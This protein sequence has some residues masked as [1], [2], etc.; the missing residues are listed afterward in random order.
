MRHTRKIQRISLAGIG[1]PVVNEDF[2]GMGDLWGDISSWAQKTIDTTVTKLQTQA[3]N[4]V[5]KAAQNFVVKVTGIDGRTQNVTLTQEQ[6][7]QYQQTG[8]FPPGVLPPGF[9]MPPQ[10][11]FEANKSVIYMAGAAIGIT[12]FGLLIYKVVKK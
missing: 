6:A 11:F 8:A 3:T 2:G 7:T 9:I 1:A 10:S 12:L 4:S 5:V